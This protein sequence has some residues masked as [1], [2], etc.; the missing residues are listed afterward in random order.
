MKV[1]ENHSSQ[2]S[3]SGSNSGSHST[4]NSVSDE[5]SLIDLILII[6]KG[7]WIVVICTLLATAAGVIYALHAPDVF[8]TSAHFITKT[9]RSSGGGNLNQLASMA[10]ISMGSG[11]S[12]DPSEYLDKVIQDY[13]FVAS[14]YERKWPL[15]NDS[16]HLEQILEI[17]PDSTVGNWERVYQMQKIER[18]R[19]GRFITINRDVRT[20]ILT[21]TTNASDPQLAYELNRYT[22]EYVSNYIRNSLQSQAREKRE[23]IEERI[24]E[25]RN[26]LNR[27]ENALVRFK[28]RN[29]MSRSPQIQLEEARLQ[30]QVTLNQ[31]IY[32][33]FQKQYEMV[34]IEELDD[35]TLVQV[36]RN[37]DVPVRRS[38]PR[39][40]QLVIFSLIGGIFLGLIGTIFAHTL[41]FITSA[42]QSKDGHNR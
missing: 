33:Q 32:L 29:L 6:W 14:L 42:V 22:L 18:V 38:R 12:I 3:A 40:T 21:L 1:K 13:N 16:L 34:R 30:R 7:K 9:G 36:V 25:V 15:G 35:Q 19:R 24:K 37:P 26:D 5:I 27:S 28:E 4:I 41:P 31:E 20:G 39:R 23:F 8:S 11:G 17:E 10:G 2:S